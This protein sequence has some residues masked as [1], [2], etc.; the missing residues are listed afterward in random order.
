MNIST[1][2]A[3]PGSV[4]K[5]KVGTCALC[6]RWRDLC[7]SHILTDSVY[8]PIYQK[9]IHEK[10]KIIAF[11]PGN[12]EL[13]RYL[14]TGFKEYLLCKGCEGHLNTS[15]EN[16]FNEFWLKKRPLDGRPDEEVPTLGGI[17][18][19]SFKLFHLSILWRASVCV[20]EAFGEVDLGPHNEIIRR[21]LL[22]KRAGPDWEYPIKCRAITQDSSIRYE[23]VV[24][25][26]RLQ[27]ERQT[28]YLFTF[29]GCEWL[30]CVSSHRNAEIERGSLRESG[31]LP[32]YR[33]ELGEVFRFHHNAAGGFPR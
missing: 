11:D 21:M 20:H 1:L 31:C 3:T 30:Y 8:G 14:Q 22:E 24:L 33:Q 19:A 23:V 6:L 9:Q 27:F 7:E 28:F 4:K 18:Y 2:K 17:D 25:P 26:K 12:P 32:V 16:P 10:H 15:Y 5:S 29:A 13:K